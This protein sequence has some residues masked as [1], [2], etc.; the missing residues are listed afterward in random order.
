MSFDWDDFSK[1]Y[2]IFSVCDWL[3]FSFCSHDKKYGEIFHD[4]HFVLFWVQNIQDTGSFFRTFHRSKLRIISIILTYTLLLAKKSTTEA[5]FLGQSQI[6]YKDHNRKT[7]KVKNRKSKVEKNL[8]FFHFWLGGPNFW[9]KHGLPDTLWEVVWFWGIP[10]L[11]PETTYI[12]YIW[13]AALCIFFATAVF[14]ES[15]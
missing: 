8:I 9:S 5:P 4:F 2:L 14:H 7:S 11:S 1:A 12:I 15:K 3:K 10:F 6:S 13:N